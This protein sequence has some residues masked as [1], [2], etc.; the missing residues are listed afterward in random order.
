MICFPLVTDQFTNRKL[1]V[2]DWKIGINLCDKERITKEEVADK[3]NLLMSSKT[4]EYMSGTIKQL[5]KMLENAVSPEGSSARNLN[6]FVENVKLQIQ[7]R[8]L[9]NGIAT[10]G[11]IS[12]D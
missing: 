2:N 8:S 1:V 6:E 5:R 4:L 3:V 7:K 12:K 10:N 9:G 11:H